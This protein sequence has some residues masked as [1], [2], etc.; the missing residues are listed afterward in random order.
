MEFTWWHGVMIHPTP[1]PCETSGQDHTRTEFCSQK[2]K[3]NVVK[4][5][6]AEGFLL[7]ISLILL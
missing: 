6:S 7:K 4:S 2:A 5:I 3:N 1:Q